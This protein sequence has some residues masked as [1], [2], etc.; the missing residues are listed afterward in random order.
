MGWYRYEGILL[1]PQR[2]KTVNLTVTQMTNHSGNSNVG[3][4]EVAMY[5]KLLC[6]WEKTKQLL[7]NLFKIIVEKNNE[8]TKW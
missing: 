3:F 6:F 8:Y 1:A 5:G 7:K 2:T 4:R